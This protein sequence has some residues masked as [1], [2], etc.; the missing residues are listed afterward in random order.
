MENNIEDAKKV[1]NYKG[2]KGHPGPDWLDE[3]LKDEKLSLKEATKLSRER[4]NATRNPYIVCKFYDLLGEMVQ[5]LGVANRPDLLWN[6]DESGMPH[7]PKK[8]KVISK[9]G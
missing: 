6:C 7:K 3:F 8:W 1:F 9:R 4:H 5:K 2:V